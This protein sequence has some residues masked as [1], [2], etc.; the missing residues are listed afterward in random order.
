MG[1]TGVIDILFS[2]KHRL[3]NPNRIRKQ[4][5]DKETHTKNSSTHSGSQDVRS[6]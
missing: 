4:V 1:S 2:N 3:D 5:Y 6:I